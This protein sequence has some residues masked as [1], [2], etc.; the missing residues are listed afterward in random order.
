MIQ[1]LLDIYPPIQIPIQHL[2]DQ[3]NA[4][5]AHDIRNTKIPIHDL[6]D[7]VKWILLV[8]DGVEENTESPHVLF[9]A[10]ICPA[11]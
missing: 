3:I 6:I 8:Y 11:G 9:F 2:A 4:R 10:T 1:N 7:T 5:L